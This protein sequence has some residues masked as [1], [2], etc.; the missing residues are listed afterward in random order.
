MRLKPLLPLLGMAFLSQL[1]A[2]CASVPPPAERRAQADALAE[3]HGW[4]PLDLPAGQFSLRVYLPARIA[5]DAELTLYIE[6]DGFAWVTANRP[7]LDPTPRTPVALQLALAQP[8]GNAAYLGRPCQYVG[9]ETAGCD[10]RYWTGARFAPELVAAMDVAV[11]R[12]KAR[13]GAERL[14]LVGYSGG[15]AVATLLAARRSD[16]TLLVTVAGNLDHRAWTR[17][18]RLSPLSA[19]LNPAD[20]RSSLGGVR[21]WHL[22]GAEDRVIPPQI[23]RDFVAGL[24]G[25]SRAQVRVMPGY[26]HHCCWAQDWA[27]LWSVL[28]GLQ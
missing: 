15:G 16:V 14:V 5:P 3:T 4:Q 21:Q 1:L 22:A 28:M 17:L 25:Q 18:H 2:G 26:D 7:S 12:V 10:R 23:S 6:G 9:V 20:W 11:D 24:P 27:E 8:G 13:F 19:S